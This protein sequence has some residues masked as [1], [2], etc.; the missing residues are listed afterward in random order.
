[1]GVL[2][3]PWDWGERRVSGVDL[4][5]QRLSMFDLLRASSYATAY[6]IFE[7]LPNKRDSATGCY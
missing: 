1:M 3:Q 5:F 2:K 7:R 4:A 6:L